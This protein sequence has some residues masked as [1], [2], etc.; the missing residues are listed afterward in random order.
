MEKFSFLLPVYKSKYLDEMLTSL[1]EQT[2]KDFSVIISD[3]CSPENIKDIC[4]PYLSDPRFHY[5]RNDKNMGSESLISHWNLLLDYC[6][7]DYV[8]I[9]S[10][11]DIYDKVFL[12]RINELIDKYPRVDLYRARTRR[13]NGDGEMYEVDRLYE[14]KE[15][16]LEFLYSSFSQDRVHCIGNYVFKTDALKRNG[17]FVDF[18]LAWFSDDATIF[19]C[20]LNGA[21]NT[22]DVLFSFRISQLN[23]SFLKKDSKLAVNKVRATC[24]FYDWM[25]AFVKGV[26]YPNTL[27]NNTLFRKV[28]EGYKSRI[29]SQIDIYYRQINFSH[30]RKLT[31]WLIG[32]KLLAS[33]KDI[34]LFIL[35]WIKSQV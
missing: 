31:K 25:N 28:C 35:R 7:T 13:I 6:N 20:C 19:K 24:R 23:I 27:Y 22:D 17:G 12:E 9:G 8:I 32:K 3:D 33:K 1:S 16:P 26:P 18:P 14:E 11:D 34:I 10:D 4:E 2:Y 29:N 30:L 15:E 21:V 5:R